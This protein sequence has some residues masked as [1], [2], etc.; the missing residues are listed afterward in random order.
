MAKKKSASAVDEHAVSFLGMARS[1]KK[2]ADLLFENDK[3][4]FSPMYFLYA[5]A[6]ELALKAFLRAQGLSIAGEPKR[7]F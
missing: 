5:H 6:S 1:Y 2:A 7:N 3:T 4:L